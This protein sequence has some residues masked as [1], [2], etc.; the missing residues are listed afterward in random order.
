MG[1]L[2]FANLWQIKDG[3]DEITVD[4]LYEQPPQPLTIP[5]NPDR[6]ATYNAQQYYKQVQQTKLNLKM[7]PSLLSKTAEDIDYLDTLHTLIINAE[8]AAEIA[9]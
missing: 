8:N 9:V 4:N 2:I 1:D 6:S 5:L 7:P 3:M